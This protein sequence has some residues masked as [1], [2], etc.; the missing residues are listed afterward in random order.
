MF[1]AKVCFAFFKLSQVWEVRAQV[2][3]VGAQLL[4]RCAQVRAIRAQLQLRLVL[5]LNY[6]CVI[7][8]T[9][10]INQLEILIV[11]LLGY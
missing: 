1:F 11:V 2:R 7:S 8:A 9:Q 10:R 3:V 4:M 6:I 5:F